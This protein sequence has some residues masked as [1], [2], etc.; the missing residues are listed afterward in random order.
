MGT[1]GGFGKGGHRGYAT[2]SLIFLSLL[3]NILIVPEEV[4]KFSIDRVSEIL[5]REFPEIHF[6]M[7]FGSSSDGKIRKNSDVDLGIY[8]DIASDKAEIIPGI[9]IALADI[10]PEDILDISILNSAGPILR[11]E[12]LQGKILF[13]RNDAEQLFSDFYAI[14]CAEY[15]DQTFWMK[16]QLE[17]RGYEVQWG[18]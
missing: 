13:V 15:E 6:A 11:F 18:N 12:A 2:Q 16:K 7:I 9:S 3:I 14:T 8:I 5:N 10:I 4:K 17:Y 1:Q